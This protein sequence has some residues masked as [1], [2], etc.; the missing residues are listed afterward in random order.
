[1]PIRKALRHESKKSRPIP[2]WSRRLYGKC[3]EIGANAQRDQRQ[4]NGHNLFQKRPLFLFGETGYFAQEFCAQNNGNRGGDAIDKNGKRVAYQRSVV[5]LYR[6]VDEC[7][8]K[9]QRHEY[10][11]PDIWFPENII[12]R[13]TLCEPGVKT[14]CHIVHLR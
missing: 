1:M 7:K 10:A 8:R 6:F 4:H 2:S 5:L 3:D 12:L 11:R 14:R 13:I 9:T